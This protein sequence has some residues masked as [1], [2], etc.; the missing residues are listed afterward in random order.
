M[1]FGTILF[2]QRG[3][4]MRSLCLPIVLV[5]CTSLFA[6]R[7]GGGG[8]G[9]SGGTGGAGGAG[10]GRNGN[11]PSLGSIPSTSPNANTPNLYPSDLLFI[12]TGKVVPDDGTTL[13]EIATL[14]TDC[15][16]QLHT[17]GHTDTRGQFSIQLGGGLQNQNSELPDA[18][19]TGSS[20]FGKSG[21]SP[22]INDLRSCQLQALLPGFT[23]QQVELA[24]KLDGDSYIDIG[25]IVVRRM[26]QA[27]GY[28]VSATSA[29]AP[30]K[31]KKRFAKGVSL[32]KKGNWAAALEKFASAVEVYPKY[33]EAWLEL[34][35]MQLKLDRVDDA[36][37]SF[38]KALEADA[39]FVPPYQEMIRIAITE[40]NWQDLSSRTEQILNLDPVSYPQYWFL[41]SAA[42]Y[43][44]RKYDVALKSA[45]R[46]EGADVQHRL[47]RLQYLLG[48]ALARNHDYRGAAAH[49]RTYLRIAPDASDAVVAETQLIQLE[50]LDPTPKPAA[51]PE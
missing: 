18:T 44:Q 5:L 12:I 4:A 14:Q 13:S 43:N 50:A 7:S 45:L 49:I 20:T 30:S 47:P 37:Q 8:G 24:S 22:S 2:S 48:L 33:A 36:K 27:Q 3:A 29:A 32:E 15:R 51:R 28:M 16:G 31:A 25:R 35:R 42:N 46:G 11:G 6:Q 23:S 26:V 38:Q 21:S 19:D 39:K 10:G 9:T 17:V 40:K 34:G 1:S 41:H